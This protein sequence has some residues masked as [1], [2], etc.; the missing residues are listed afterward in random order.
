MTASTVYPDA[1][2]LARGAAELFLRTGRAALDDR[3]AF[4]VALAGGSTPRAMYEILAA[5][6][7][8]ID[9]PGVEIFFGDERCIP[10]EHPDSNSGAARRALLSRVPLDPA[11]I[12]P[13]RGALGPRAAAD[14]YEQLLRR[15]FAGPD[16][17]T[18]DLVLLG[19]GVD[20]HTLSLF[21]GHNFAADQR[22]WCVPA[23]APP[24]SPVRDRVTLTLDAVARARAACFLIAGPDKA[25]ALRRVRAA[26]P[27]GD[28]RTPASLVRC[29]SPVTWLTDRAAEG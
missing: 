15:R 10:P 23:V 9:W 27:A 17:T 11:H 26:P 16:P 4:T 29:R 18:F 24:A 5:D 28:P 25:A 8:G 22:R 13:M 2:A 6:P 7:R 19:M 20:G 14:D 12:H 3:G 1:P 21:P